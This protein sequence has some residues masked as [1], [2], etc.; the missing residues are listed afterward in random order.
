MDP[1]H[2]NQGYPTLRVF[3]SNAIRHAP[4]TFLPN[5]STVWEKNSGEDFT[6]H[7]TEKD[8]DPNVKVY[9]N[10]VL[11]IRDVHYSVEE[12]STVITLF[13]SFLDTLEE[14]IHTLTLSFSDGV[15]VEDHFIIVE[16]II[17]PDN[18]RFISFV[19][20]DE[21]W[22]VSSVEFGDQANVPEEPKKDCCY[23]FTGWYYD[24]ELFDFNAP[25]TD[26]II[27]TAKWSNRIWDPNSI[28]MITSATCEKDGF[29]SFQCVYCG[30]WFVE[31]IIDALGHSY[32]L[33]VIDSELYNVCE[34]CGDTV[35]VGFEDVAVSAAV[36]KSNGNKNELTVTITG[37]YGDL[38]FVIVTE[39]I[40][41]NNNA[42]GVYEIGSFRVYVD[43]KGNTQVRE[44]YIVE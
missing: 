20:G 10:G 18:I 26:N 19:D 5:S 23:I 33:T 41:I 17:I 30:D 7:K 15:I 16:E 31:K 21:I 12:G 11:L 28:R 34:T 40:L 38:G 39:T 3:D 14:G 9:V 37:H 2:N 44:V 25:I 27:L 6:T 4:N 13:P 32:V 35:F 29:I 8:F 36:L 42:A 24:D 1:N 43:T 22:E